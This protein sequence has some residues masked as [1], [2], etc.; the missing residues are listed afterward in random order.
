MKNCKSCQQPIPEARLRALPHTQTCVNCSDVSRVA[1]YMQI[2][3]KTGNTIGITDQET[4]NRI[5][6]AQSRKGV[7]V[8]RGVRM[9]GK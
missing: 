8:S 4:A 5:Y 1:G 7:G 9:K 2:N 3:G 6:E